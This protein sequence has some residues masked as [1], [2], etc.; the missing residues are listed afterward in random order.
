MIED[1]VPELVGYVC[2]IGRYPSPAIPIVDNPHYNDDNDRYLAVY[3]DKIGSKTDET[4]HTKSKFVKLSSSQK[5]ELVNF[6][7]LK[8]RLFAVS[9]SDICSYP[10][11]V[12]AEREF[13]EKLL[14]DRNFS[15]EDPFFRISLAEEVG[16]LDLL[17]TELYSCAQYIDQN[18]PDFMW[19]LNEEILRLLK[20]KIICLRDWFIIDMKIRENYEKQD[21]ISVIFNVTIAA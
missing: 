14:K 12:E 8:E 19:L 20:E 9:K 7:C 18:D 1:R 13:F 2:P 6:N 17:K 21:F 5:K 15:R 11:Q 4:V 3:L 10:Y 16:K